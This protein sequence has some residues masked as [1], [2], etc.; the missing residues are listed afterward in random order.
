LVWQ[1]QKKYYLWSVRFYHL[2]LVLLSHT[3]V[4]FEEIRSVFSLHPSK[5]TVIDA[6]LGLGGHAS[7]LISFLGN[8]DELIGFD[9][10]RDNFVL[11]KEKLESIETQAKVSLYNESFAQI[12]DILKEEKKIDFILYDLWV[13]SLHYDDGSRG[14]SLRMDGPLDMRFDRTHGRTAE[15]FIH[16]T[17]EEELARVFFRY[18]DEPKSRYIA[19]ALVE[20]RKN[21]RIDTTAKLRD[22]IAE[23]SFDQKSPLRCFQALRIAVNDEFAHIEDSLEYAIQ[24]LAPGGKIA[25]ITFH[26]LED[27]LVK[28]IFAE[29]LKDEQDEITGQT[30]VPALLSKYTKKPIEPT[31]D[32]IAENPRSR[33]AKLRIVEK[34]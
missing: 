33:S 24:H 23:A 30:K 18:A 3:P 1:E 19:R 27:R 17:S 20:K 25:V 31:P 29:Y 8:W 22:I 26:S 13:S 6:T 9:R 21:M 11:A 32:E 15:D 12:A 16:T 4:L 34:K 7:M 5:K 14:F 28:N 2:S 10:D